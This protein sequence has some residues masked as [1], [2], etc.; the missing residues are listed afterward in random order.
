[1][2]SL[3]IFQAG[4]MTAKGFRPSAPAVC[5]VALAVVLS[6]LLSW[7][8]AADFGNRLGFD[9]SPDAF[10]DIDGDGLADAYGVDPPRNQGVS[11]T[12]SRLTVYRNTGGGHLQEAASWRASGKIEEV[13]AADLDGG[14]HAELIASVRDPDTYDMSMVLLTFKGWDLKAYERP[15]GFEGFCNLTGDGRIQVRGDAHFWEMENGSLRMI[16]ADGPV[17]Y[18]D[19]ADL[20]LDGR[21]EVLTIPS[22]STKSA[23]AAVYTYAGGRLAL[24]SSFTLSPPEGISTQHEFVR[25]SHSIIKAGDRYITD[26]PAMAFNMTSTQKGD[27]ETVVTGLRSNEG[28]SRCTLVFWD[29]AT[30]QLASTNGMV[31]ILSRAA[32]PGETPLPD[33]NADGFPDL[34]YS[35]SATKEIATY[36]SRLDSGRLRYERQSLGHQGEIV[37]KIEDIDRDGRPDIAA[38]DFGGPRI[39]LF[40]ND[41]AGRFTQAQSMPFPASSAS[42]GVE[43]DWGL[44]F[45]DL[46]RDGM[47]DMLAVNRNPTGGFKVFFGEGECRFR[48]AGFHE[49]GPYPDNA[50]A[51]FDAGHDFNGDGRPDIVF[52][53]DWPERYYVLLNDGKGAFPDFRGLQMAALVG[54][55]SAAALLLA[56]PVFRAD[57]PVWAGLSPVHR[58]KSRARVW[59]ATVPFILVFIAWLLFA[60]DIK[61]FRQ[62]MGL[63]ILYSVLVPCIPPIA[64]AGRPS[65][66]RFAGILLGSSWAMLAVA[67]AF[68]AMM[69]PGLLSAP[70]TGRLLSTVI[71]YGSIIPLFLVL[72]FIGYRRM[73]AAKPGPLPSAPVSPELVEYLDGNVLRRYALHSGARAY[74]LERD[75][76]LLL[77]VTWEQGFHA[78]VT[79]GTG[80][81]V[82]SRDPA[83]L[84][85]GL[86]RR[87][88]QA[89]GAPDAPPPEELRKRWA[90]AKGAND[91]GPLMGNVVHEEAVY[92]PVFAI[93]LAA[94]LAV[95]VK[96]SS[97]AYYLSAAAIIGTIPAMLSVLLVVNWRS[98]ARVHA[99]AICHR[100]ALFRERTWFVDIRRVVPLR[101]FA[102]GRLGPMYDATRPSHYAVEKA[103]GG[104]FHISGESTL[105]LKKAMGPVWA[106]AF[107]GAAF[108]SVPEP[109]NGRRWLPT[110]TRHFGL[111]V[112]ALVCGFFWACFFTVLLLGMV[113]YNVDW[114]WRGPAGLVL[115][116]FLVS[117]AY[118]AFGALAIRNLLDWHLGRIVA[119]KAALADPGKRQALEALPNAPALLRAAGRASV[120][121]LPAAMPRPWELRGVRAARA[122]SAAV[123]CL[124]LLAPAF[125]PYP[126]AGHDENPVTGKQKEDRL[127]F[128]NVTG[129]EVMRG[130]DLVVPGDIV[131][132]GSLTL[133]NCTLNMS[134]D[135]RVN[136]SLSMSGCRITRGLTGSYY[137]CSASDGR[138]MISLD[139]SGASSAS[140]SFSSGWDLPRGG[141]MTLRQDDSVLWTAAGKAGWNRTAV[142][143]DRLCGKTAVLDF[144]P[145]GWDG[146]SVF[147]LYDIELRTDGSTR[148]LGSYNEL[149][150]HGWQTGHSWPGTSI[151]A[152]GGSV[153]IR[154]TAIMSTY[155]GQGF[156]LD[157]STLNLS[158]VTL[159][160]PDRWVWRDIEAV[161]SR[162][163]IQRSRIVNISIGLDRSSLEMANSTL[164][165]TYGANLRAIDSEVHLEDCRLKFQNDGLEFVN[166]T[167]GVRNCLINSTR[168]FRITPV[169]RTP[170]RLADSLDIS[171]NAF[172]LPGNYGPYPEAFR[173]FSSVP[174]SDLPSL[175]A[176]NADGLENYDWGCTVYAGLD[177]V[178]RTSGGS[179]VQCDLESRAEWEVRVLDNATNL[180]STRVEKGEWAGIGETRVS[181]NANAKTNA[182]MYAGDGFPAGRMRRTAGGFE[183]YAPANSTVSFRAESYL[184]LAGAAADVSRLT[185]VDELLKVELALADVCDLGLEDASFSVIDESGSLECRFRVTSAGRSGDLTAVLRHSSGIQASMESFGGSSGY[186]VLELPLDAIAG[187]GTLTLSVVSERSPDIDPANNNLSWPVERLA[188]G[189]N[190]TGAVTAPVLWLLDN[191][192][193]GFRDCVL[194][195]PNPGSR[196]LTYGRD[197]R[198]DFANTTLLHEGLHIQAAS[199]SLSASLDR[200]SG[201]GAAGS[202]SWLGLSGDEIAISDCSF[203]Y[204]VD[205]GRATYS[206][207]G[208][209]ISLLR[210]KFSNATAYMFGRV[211]MLN[212]TVVDSAEID[213]F[214]ESD[215]SVDGCSFSNITAFIWSESILTGLSFRNNTLKDYCRFL[216]YAQTDVEGFRAANN[217]SDPAREVVDVRWQAG[218]SI[219]LGW[220]L[221]LTPF[222]VSGVIVEYAGLDG[223]ATVDLR[224]GSAGGVYRWTGEFS[225]GVAKFNESGA[226]VLGS[227]RYTVRVGTVLGDEKSYSGTVPVTGNKPVEIRLE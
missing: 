146:K 206:I 27:L 70:S 204:W 82:E 189:R 108:T 106:E 91:A 187:N 220:L 143:L 115:V 66:G 28:A 40:R 98:S 191:S 225:F 170:C 81:G 163:S 182:Q 24:S 137:R 22:L 114:G 153:D 202:G 96:V 158:G 180:L 17:G 46:D 104:R 186:S 48:E 131:V 215:S 183:Q 107:D 52:G 78:T 227:L 195:F 136:G 116:F 126:P 32:E 50:N 121:H 36:I 3:P 41:G 167:G 92:F 152:G 199:L 196:I 168:P 176:R 171:G 69:T 16:P 75:P 37:F 74:L 154:D 133:E 224:S 64:A 21:D 205:D 140:L 45:S 127:I 217:F 208:D 200:S 181:Y 47:P 123:M 63:F 122:S 216:I 169:P 178:V 97:P 2:Y 9:I 15:D 4:T 144:A 161:N 109:K 177:P 118:V 35:F 112:G 132:G 113:A 130:L 157:N 14:R 103:D 218:V 160:M 43:E 6:A 1:M 95:L 20:N 173:I 175:I 135:F 179:L 25:P 94:A 209:N 124:L 139:L 198:L 101:R 159:E 8:Y 219:G 223:N 226:H 31:V 162:L 147:F 151:R 128:M 221:N 222:E 138:L 190:F 19:V 207:E 185:R 61:D 87:M 77:T 5:V 166:S 80:P 145:S 156:V 111:I 55:G 89:D 58:L 86:T 71:V 120:R 23:T 211:R 201:I 73:Q 68:R 129:T 65:R 88:E 57:R 150:S 194:E 13:A 210:T 193:Y 59:P 38:I 203:G 34:V 102:H 184:G 172:R 33:F 105:L 134:G 155:Y 90:D 49:W 213:L 42:D 110:P 44:F 174:V 165:A 30:R 62:G 7:S 212:C 149:A 67:L 197:A 26:R 93:L 10:L 76:P 84:V 85:A 83:A 79:A 100:G 72:S 192:T 99:N 56:F 53:H 11:G 164:N 148:E 18:N 29:N 142:A 117:L 125:I 214:I 60:S 188:G 119:I 54:L 51:L 39:R 12:R 141:S